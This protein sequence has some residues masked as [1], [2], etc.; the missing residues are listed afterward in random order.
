MKPWIL[1]FIFFP[2]YSS[3]DL[4]YSYDYHSLMQASCQERRYT[5]NILYGRLDV[6]YKRLIVIEGSMDRDAPDYYKREHERLKKEYEL[7]QLILK[8]F[9]DK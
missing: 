9:K 7:L 5:Y 3:T 1:L 8:Q 6:I 4:V 2:L